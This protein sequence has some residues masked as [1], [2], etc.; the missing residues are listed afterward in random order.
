M[1][2]QL[3]DQVMYRLA[4]GELQD[5]DRL[6]SIRSV[7][8]ALR[9]NP[10]TVIKA[11]RELEHLGFAQSRHGAGYFIACDGLESVRAD[12]RV[13]VLKNLREMACRA[14]SVG[15]TAD[16]IRKAVESA[17]SEGGCHE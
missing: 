2:R 17:I 1:Y 8:T 7:C 12:W 11:Y 16:S 4:S 6:P 15:V 3:V 14:I 10:N 13:R 9:I 5:G